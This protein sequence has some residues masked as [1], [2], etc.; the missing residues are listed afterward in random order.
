MIPELKKEFRLQ[1]DSTKGDILLLL[2]Y[3]NDDDPLFLEQ[4]RADQ[5]YIFE[6][7]LGLDSLFNIS[8]VDNAY[9]LDMLW[10]KFFASGKYR[11]IRTLVDALELVK[12]KGSIE[13][14]Q[15]SNQDPALENDAYLEATYRSLIWSLDVNSKTFRLVQDYLSYIYNKEQLPEDVK[16]ELKLILT[17]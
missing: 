14:Y 15:Q 12:Y 16:A 1:N 6:Q 17:K 3:L 10:T 11:P 7:T 9:Q 4:L 2:A 13:K 8:K 5:R